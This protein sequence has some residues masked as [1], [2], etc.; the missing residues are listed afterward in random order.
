MLR[1]DVRVAQVT[2]VVQER[3]EQ[4]EEQLT[5]GLAPHVLTQKLGLRGEQ[6]LTQSLEAE[7]GPGLREQ[8]HSIAER[9]RIFGTQTAHR[10]APDV[11]DQDVRAN[12]ACRFD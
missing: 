8:P 3:E 7:D 4:V 9:M 6:P 5:V 10:G 11:T 12:V 1:R 2:G